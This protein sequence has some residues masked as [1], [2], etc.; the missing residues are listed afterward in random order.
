MQLLA[1]YEGRG[2]RRGQEEKGEEVEYEEGEG[3][4]EYKSRDRGRRNRIRSQDK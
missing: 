4:V 1:C 2:G 3:E